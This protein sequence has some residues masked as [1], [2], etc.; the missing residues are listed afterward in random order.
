[1]KSSCLVHLTTTLAHASGEWSLRIGR[2]APS[3]KR[4]LRT[5]WE[6]Y[7][8][9]TLVG[10]AELWRTARADPLWT[11]QILRVP[12]TFLIAACLSAGNGLFN[13]AHIIGYN[14]GFPPRG[15]F[16]RRTRHASGQ[17]ERSRPVRRESI[18]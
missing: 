9:F 13:T 11:R 3:V 6:R 12:D 14:P 1:M 16:Q 7:A 8:L 18:G 4:R 5:G 17:K 10:I 2:C 15:R